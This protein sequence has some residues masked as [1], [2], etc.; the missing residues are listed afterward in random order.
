MTTQLLSGKHTTAKGYSQCVCV[1]VCVTLPGSTEDETQKLR[2]LTEK[3][4]CAD[5]HAAALTV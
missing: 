2:E 4:F 5:E 3:S 1:C